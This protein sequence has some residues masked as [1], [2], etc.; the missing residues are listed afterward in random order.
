MLMFFLFGRNWLEQFHGCLRHLRLS[1]LSIVYKALP[2]LLV[3]FE[4]ETANIFVSYVAIYAIQ[5]GDGED[6]QR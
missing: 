3:S 5:C 2:I 4:G 1:N 6:E